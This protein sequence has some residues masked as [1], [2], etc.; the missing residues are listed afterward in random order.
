MPRPARRAWLPVVG[1]AIVLGALTPSA[2]ADCIRSGTRGAF[3]ST[4]RAGEPFDVLARPPR[5][6]RAR[7]ARDLL[8][9]GVWREL[10]RSYGAA[11]APYGGPGKPYELFVVSAATLDED[12][13]VQAQ[14]CDRL[15][16]S[17][18]LVKA[19]ISNS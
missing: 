7:R 5:L 9:A 19:G 15:D 1:A 12:Y 16:R 11:P 13:G 10:V 18:I 4:H 2:L 8:A 6:S 14:W 17:G 3:V